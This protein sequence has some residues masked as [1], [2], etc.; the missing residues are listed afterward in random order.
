[1]LYQQMFQIKHHYFELQ[2]SKSYH[3]YLLRLD[4]ELDAMKEPKSACERQRI[5]PINGMLAYRHAARL[6]QA[7][8]YQH[9]PPMLS[10]SI[11][12]DESRR[13]LYLR[14]AQLLEKAG[15]IHAVSGGSFYCYRQK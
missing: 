10:W 7:W 15:Y 14:F 11:G 12:G 5:S 1:M 3:V 4:C 2:V 8:V 9:K 6:L 13:P